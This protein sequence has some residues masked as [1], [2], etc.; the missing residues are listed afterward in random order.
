MGSR[1]KSMAME[2]WPSGRA[3]ATPLVLALLLMV[4]AMPHSPLHSTGTLWL[5]SH[6]TA[7]AGFPSVGNLTLLTV[8]TRDNV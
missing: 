7:I 4:L 2:E 5:R 8:L 6:V 3:T 1:F